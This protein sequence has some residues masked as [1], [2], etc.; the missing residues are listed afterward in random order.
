[1]D[2]AIYVNEYL[3]L[4]PLSHPAMEST[5]VFN[6]KNWRLDDWQDTR[7]VTVDI[8]FSERVQNNGSLFAHIF[9][10]RSGAVLDPSNPAYDSTKAFRMVKMLIRYMPK[11]KVIKTKKLIGGGEEEEADEELPPVPEVGP[12]IASYWH[13]NLTLDVISN[14]GVLSFN[15]LP[16]TM[17]QHVVL[18][19]TGARDE[20][21]RNGWY[22]PIFFLNEF[23]LLKEHM[24]EINSTVKYV[25]SPSLH[26]PH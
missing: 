8:P 22:Y 17:R 10:A 12:S 1:M 24:V 20:T 19:S 21:G 15:T 4:P 25:P 13:S 18:E 16:P 3:A 14:G 6:E 26:K 7:S 2:I 9:V 23:W 5:L 11:K